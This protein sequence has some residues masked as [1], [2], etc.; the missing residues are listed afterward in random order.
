MT[1]VIDRDLQ[2]LLNSQSAALYRPPHRRA[3]GGTNDDAG[4]SSTRRSRCCSAIRW[5][6]FGQSS[7]LRYTATRL[8][9]PTGVMWRQATMTTLWGGRFD[10]GRQPAAA[11]VQRL[12]ALRPAPVAGGHLRQHG[13]CQ[14]HRR[15]RAAQRPRSATRCWPG[16]SRWPRSGAAASSS[17]PP[18]TRT[19]TRP[20]SA[21]W[22]S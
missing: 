11:A 9:T 22:A 7:G 19:S 6:A 13:L 21:G 10:A 18:A 1:L 16:W 14:R 12:A 8:L 2:H 4:A 15:G 5:I 17:S 3:A 20:S